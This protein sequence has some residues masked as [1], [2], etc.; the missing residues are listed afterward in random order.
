[1]EQGKAVSLL[2]RAYKHFGHESY[3]QAT[4]QGIE[5]MIK[6]ISPGGKVDYSNDG[7][8]LLKYT[9]YKAVLNGWIFEWWGLYDYCL[10]TSDQKVASVRDN[11]RK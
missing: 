9:H 5:F 7:T 3:F 2:C 11:S 1:M 6:P 8:I 4:K 10:L